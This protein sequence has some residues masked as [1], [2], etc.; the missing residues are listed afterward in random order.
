MV[1]YYHNI[2][3]LPL[4]KLQTLQ[5]YGFGI[6]VLNNRTFHNNIRTINEIVTYLHVG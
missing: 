1:T 2:S 5:K 3:Y 6:G 4:D